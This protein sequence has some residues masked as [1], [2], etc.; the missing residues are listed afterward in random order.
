VLKDILLWSVMRA[1]MTLTL[2]PE[3][4]GTVM[5]PLKGK[6]SFLTKVEGTL[7]EVG[8]KLGVSL[9]GGGGVYVIGLGGVMIWIGEGTIIIGTMV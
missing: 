2:T 8:W 5:E 4:L 1:K 6:A 9:A 7:W 3:G